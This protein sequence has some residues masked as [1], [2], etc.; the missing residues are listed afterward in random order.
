[1]EKRLV[2]LIWRRSWALIVQG[3]CRAYFVQ[4]NSM[5]V[6]ARLQGASSQTTCFIETQISHK[7]ICTKIGWKSKE[8]SNRAFTLI[9]LLV[10]IAII[11]ILAA[12]LLP[13]L[14][15]SK[16]RAMGATCLNNQKQLALGW[17]MYVNDNNGALMNFD[18]IK[19]AAGDTPWRFASPNPS[20]AIPPGTDVKTKAMLLL[21]AGYAQGSL[22][23]Y[24][25]N[26]N[27]LHCPADGRS[28]NSVV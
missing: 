7:Q 28:G 27:V 19:N 26:V 12:M 10:V 24:A 17:G 18:T 15:K 1:M 13:A 20:P 6:A 23:Q 2:R 16:S 25:P 5:G 4:L 9:E 8:F 22:F 14:S 3:F 21:Q 11:A